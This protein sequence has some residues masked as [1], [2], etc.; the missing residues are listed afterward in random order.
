MWSGLRDYT[1]SSGRASRRALDRIYADFT[2][3]VAAGRKLPKEQVLE[4]ARGRVWTGE[5]ALGLGLVDELGG[6][7][8]AL[9]Q[10]REA[11]GLAADA[12]LAPGAVPAARGLLGGLVGRFVSPDDDAEDEEPAVATLRT[13]SRRSTRS[14]AR[15]ARPASWGAGRAGGRPAPRHA[16]TGLVWQRPQNARYI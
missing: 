13:A 7:P 11:L 6:Y 16:V 15:C 5:D 14:P 9:R 1:P 3:K 10:V 12:P 4:V 2:S 8:E